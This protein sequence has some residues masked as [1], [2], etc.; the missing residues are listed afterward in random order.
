M[1]LTLTGGS[2]LGDGGSRSST[3]VHSNLAKGVDGTMNGNDGVQA[4][5]GT[6]GQQQ[7]ITSSAPAHSHNHS[8]NH[9]HGQGRATGQCC[10][11]HAPQ[12]QQPRKID[13]SALLPTEEVARRFR[14]DKKFRLGVLSNVVR[15]GPYGLFLSLLTVLVSNEN[16]ESVKK[17]NDAEAEGAAAA[18]EER[19]ESIVKG[20]DPESLA[21]MLDGYGADGH[22]LAHWC[23]KRGDEPRFLS[24]LIGKSH[25]SNGARLLIDLHLPSK[26]SV[27]MYPLHWAVTEGAVPLVSML[28]QH[29]EERP[30]PSQRSSSSSGAASSSSL[31]Q[32]E[33]DADGSNVNPLNVGIDAQDAS[34]CTPLLIASQYGHPDLAAFLIKRG[35]NPNAVDS[36][37]D[38]ALHWAAYKGSVEVCGMLLHLHGVEGQL[39][40]PDSFGQTPLHLAS[41]RGNAETVQFL[42]EEA[43]SVGERGL[44]LGSTGRVGSKANRSSRA[45]FL[46]PGKLLA[47][48]DKE[49]KTPRDLAVKKKKLGCELL[50]QEYEEQYLLPKRSIFSRLGQMCRDLFSLQSWKAWMGMSGA[51]LPIGQSPTFPFYWMTLHI[52]LGGLFYAT[53]FVGLGRRRMTG[54]DSLLWDKIGLH[55][56]FIISWCSTWCNL[57]YV[58]TTNPGVLDARRESNNTPSS[59]ATCQLLCCS[60]GAGGYPRDKVSVEMDSVTKELRQ[61]YDDTIES[62]S[63]DFPSPD[64]RL[65]LCHTCRIVRPPR[66]KH[67][68]VARRCIL[69]FDHHCP[70]VGT[71]VGLYNYLYFY[72]FLISFCLMEGGFLTAWVMFLKRS[73]SFPKGAFLMGAYFALYTAP[74]LMM[75]FYHTTLILNNISTNEQLNA[76]KYRYLWD[77]SKRF[78][79]PFD[80]GKIRNILQR[81]WP[82]RSSYQ[83]AQPKRRGDVELG[84]IALPQDN[85]EKQSLISNAV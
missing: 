34:G 23:A 48:R 19:D 47:M 9:G 74:V 75:A 39:D 69:V 61:Q 55:L 57:Y 44:D 80:H 67:C 11:A 16:D 81:C 14:S 45:S 52:L 4:A 2:T 31:M 62:F 58:Y 49:E 66:S 79:N 29:L 42:M 53:E 30:S 5:A 59:P 72:L 50:L 18:A 22:T 68:R 8:P 83:L 56:F 3:P 71:T 82:D 84:H 64:K 20:A 36:S 76:R 35:A 1:E 7:G 78:R 46:Y 38:T 6:A 10:H 37:R 51:N 85:E 15:G 21:Q 24:F 28:L 33:D 73:Q 65:P 12:K 17:K 32:S 25:A 40:A 60:R 13:A 63:K 54:D 26:D 70:F 41:L 27:G 77:E 43:G